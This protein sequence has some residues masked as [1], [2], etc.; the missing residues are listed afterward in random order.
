MPLTIADRQSRRVGEPIVRKYHTKVTYL[1]SLGKPILRIT[2]DG[3]KNLTDCA[4]FALNGCLDEDG[5]RTESNCGPT[6]KPARWEDYRGVAYARQCKTPECLCKSPKFD[7]SFA[8]A[9]D[10][11]ETYCG[12]WVSVEALRNQ[13]YED[14]QNVF[15]TF[16]A[17]VG[18]PPKNWTLRVTGYAPGSNTT[19]VESKSRSGG[20]IPMHE[21]TLW[22]P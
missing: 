3:Y 6:S 2:S 20:R 11:G 21:N 4:K 15:A 17:S 8:V 9:Y 10:A 14:M 18:F 7:A 12:M 1:S 16:C 13:E 22:V 19:S 5:N